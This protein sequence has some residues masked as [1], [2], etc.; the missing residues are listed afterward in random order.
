RGLVG[1]IPVAE[2]RIGVGSVHADDENDQ[3]PT[4]VV[5][6]ELALFGSSPCRRRHGCGPDYGL[7]LSLKCVRKKASMSA[8]NILWN[9]MRSKSGASAQPR[10]KAHICP[11][12]Q[13]ARKAQCV[14]F[15]TIRFSGFDGR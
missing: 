13:G 11:G 1:V 12:E 2:R 3:R 10:G 5:D 15:G 7:P 4:Q 9:A 14:A 6:V 8:L